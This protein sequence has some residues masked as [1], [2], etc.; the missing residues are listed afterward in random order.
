MHA[1]DAIVQ[2]VLGVLGAFNDQLAVRDLDGV[3]GLFVSDPDADQ[4]V[5]FAAGESGGASWLLMPGES[6][7]A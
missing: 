6:S 4:A 3:L 5:S 2:Q 1:D 7:S